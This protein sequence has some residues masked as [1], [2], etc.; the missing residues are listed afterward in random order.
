MKAILKFVGR[1]SS[2]GRWCVGLA[3]LALLFG[4]VAVAQMGG[5][6]TI[7]F[8]QI[9]TGS[10]GSP[11]Q[12]TVTLM[13]PS[14]SSVSVQYATRDG[15]AVAG[16]DYQ[17]TTGNLVFAPGETSKR[18]QITALNVTGMGVYACLDL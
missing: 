18:V 5:G 1:H 2:M 17:A 8:G 10:S 13:P 14:T 16:T 9:T 6:S 7:G 3:L 11:A 4:S 12:V 15:T